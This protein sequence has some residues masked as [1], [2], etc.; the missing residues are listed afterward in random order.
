MFH[1]FWWSKSSKFVI[2]SKIEVTSSFIADVYQFFSKYRRLNVAVIYELTSPD[3]GKRQ[4]IMLINVL[5]NYYTK[6]NS[7][8]DSDLIF[9]DYLKNLNGYELQIVGTSQS[10]RLI[11]TN[12]K[13][14]RG[15]DVL[16]LEVMA[17]KQ[18]ATFSIEHVNYQKNEEVQNFN[19]RMRTG[20]IDLNLNTMNSGGTNTVL[21]EFFKN[22]NTYDV[23]GYC[24]L[25]PNPPRKSFL[26]FLFTP[27][28][29]ISWL[30]MLIC[31]I[32]LAF[33]WRIFKEQ[34]IKPISSVGRIVLV[35]IAGFLGQGFAFTT[36][37][38]F[39]S[40]V[41]QLIVIVVWILGTIYQSLL[42]SLMTESRN[43]TR[44]TTVKEMMQGDYNYQTDVL[45]DKVIQRDYPEIRNRVKMNFDLY[46]TYINPYEK[47]AADNTV[48]IMRCDVVDAMM[49]SK[50]YLYSFGK[51]VDF[52]YILPQKFMAIYNTLSTGRFNPFVEKFAE[53]S[54]RIFESGIKQHWTILLSE[55]SNRIDMEL[56]S[57]I[58]EDFLLK[59]DDI[60]YVFLIMMFGLSWATSVFAAEKINSKYRDTIRKLKI[61][62][63]FRS[64]TWEERV[65]NREKLVTTRWRARQVI[66]DETF[67]MIQC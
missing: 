24:A 49:F 16:L 39:H 62:R 21:L 57:V 8:T 64:L 26:R 25:I 41:M 43:G 7:T 1:P 9:P 11:Y 53:L 52:Y 54:L 14:F 17:K 13:Q 18:N 30:F 58:N 4:T 36:T 38:W 20:A 47:T 56:I 3:G 40:L 37:R 51:P 2:L 55:S 45:F 66:E 29:W 15:I 19:R 60:K 28:D 10:P 22:F 5:R 65:R 31:I 23:G 35:A 63:I 12:S 44:I 46:V 59:M 33:A 61:V 42:I 48:L 27:F 32:V 50:S 6:Y 34:E 67:E